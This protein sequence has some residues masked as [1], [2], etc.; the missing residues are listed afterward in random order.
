[1]SA[2]L[3]SSCYSPCALQIDTCLFAY[4]QAGAKALQAVLRLVLEIP[5]LP[6]LNFVSWDKFWWAVP[7]HILP[8][9]SGA[10]VAA[11]GSGTT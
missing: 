1:M 8:V 9:L 10:F 6:H 2:Q 11:E 7:G 5:L 4:G 3:V